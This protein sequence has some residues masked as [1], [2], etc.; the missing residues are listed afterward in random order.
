MHHPWV[1]PCL[2]GATSAW[3]YF[4]ATAASF[5]VIMVSPRCCNIGATSM[6]HPALSP[7]SIVATLTCGLHLEL[8]SMAFR[9]HPRLEL[10]VRAFTWILCLSLPPQS[11]HVFLGLI[12]P[13]HPHLD[14]AT[15]SLPY[16]DAITLMWL[17]HSAPLVR[18]WKPNGL[19]LPQHGKKMRKNGEG[20]EDRGGRK[21]GDVGAMARIRFPMG[22]KWELLVSRKR[23][24]L[25]K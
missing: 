6:L 10:L 20:R 23:E 15:P 5:N 24:C 14:G 8:T 11:L 9:H 1:W 16:L 21:E 25:K 12:S 7:H 22:N 13:L 17:L 3:L 2:D 19:G 4:N 18:P